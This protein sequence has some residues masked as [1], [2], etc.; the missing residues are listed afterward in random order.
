MSYG[1]PADAGAEQATK[2]RMLAD[3]NDKRTVFLMNLPQDLAIRELTNMFTFAPGFLKAQLYNAKPTDEQPAKL[4]AFVLFETAQQAAT[5]M[6][7]LKLFKFDPENPERQVDSRLAVK[8][9]HMNPTEAQEIASKRLKLNTVAA[10]PYA[11]Q[12]AAAASTGSYA[13]QY[14]HASYP[15][16]PPSAQYSAPTQYAQQYPGYGA[17]YAQQYPGYGGYPAAGYG[18]YTD[19]AAAAPRSMGSL[20]DNPPIST[21]YLANLASMDEDTLVSFLHSKC[22]GYKDHK[23]SVDKK[24]T[25][26]AWVLFDNVEL[27]TAAMDML[28]TQQGVQCAYSRNALNKRGR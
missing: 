27:A 9:L 6:E 12:H 21:L 22:A 18:G 2:K 14:A 19:P 26:V 4:G 13:A 5:V 8:N 10:D 1:P 23:L 15:S 16:Y 25:R 20:K 17:Q 11:A 24:G 7:S 3:P 28:S